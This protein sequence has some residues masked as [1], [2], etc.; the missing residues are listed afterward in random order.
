MRGDVYEME[1]RPAKGHEQAGDRLGVIIQS[2]VFAW[3]TVVVAPTSTSARPGPLRPQ[4]ELGEAKTAVLVDQM[5]AVD[6]DKRL[7]R[8]V[9]RVSLADLQA[10]EKAMRL[11]L[12]L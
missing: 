6:P 8:M 12:A 4:I 7:G 5:S 2:D 11:V 3:S 1:P 9:G 10:I